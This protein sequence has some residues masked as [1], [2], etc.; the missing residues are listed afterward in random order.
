[1]EKNA[2]IGI[3]ALLIIVV[4]G[5]LGGG[6]G[7]FLIINQPT[8]VT[9]GPIALSFTDGTFQYTFTMADLKSSK[10]TQVSNQMFVY[11]YGSGYDNYTF[12]GVSLKSIIEEENILAKSDSG[13][14]LA[15]NLTF[16][17][18][19]GFDP[20]TM[21]PSLGYLNLTMVMEADYEECIIAYG[22]PD[23]DPADG[24]LRSAINL[25]ACPDDKP[26]TKGYFAK[27]LTTV[28]ILKPTSPSYEVAQAALTITDENFQYTFTISELQSS[29]YTQVSNQMFVYDYGS[30]YDNYTFSGVS[31]KSIIEEENILA[32]SDLGD[33]L[34]ENLTF[35]GGDGFDPAIM[36]PSLGYL[37]LTMVMEADYE[38]CIIAYGG[39][40]L[41]PAD[42][43]LRSAINITAC[44]DDLPRTKGFFAKNLTD[45]KIF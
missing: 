21:G 42:G 9:E 32:K 43:P 6:I 25:S 2:K 14:Y 4:A 1:M 3:A 13:D 28:K 29:K 15:E 45:I 24:P 27:N 44:P 26:K 31:L 10:Y 23:L 19:D 39:P 34:A 20:A 36:G 37:N 18:A 30:G 8:T 17:A 41:D 5:G 33:Y 7:A 12:S 22:G 40:D 11:D 16:I 38:E 35:V